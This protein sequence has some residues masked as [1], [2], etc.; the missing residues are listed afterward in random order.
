MYSRIRE[1]RSVEAV[2]LAKIAVKSVIRASFLIFSVFVSNSVYAAADLHQ[3][4]TNVR[5]IIV[6]LTSMLMVISFVIG[7]FLIFRALGLMKKFGINVAMHQS[8][9]DGGLSK[10][11]SY[12][13]VGAI[14]IYLPT[15]TDFMM[16]S[17]FSSYNSIF[18]YGGSINYSAL[19]DG[20]SLMSYSGGTSF[21]QNWADLAKTLVLYIQFL[22][23]ISFIKGWLMLSKAGNPHAQQG[24]IGKGITH[25]VGG[26][27]LI[28]IVGVF[29]ILRNTV[30]GA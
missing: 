16:N 3:I 13:I 6:P 29:N 14:L 20:A 26:I 10:P 19:G 17:I 7:I 24:Q 22:G 21:E 25:V 18:G 11:L 4:L 28:N 27:G 1:L 12:L 2:L 5:G 8:N 30:F 9:D 23:F 15:T